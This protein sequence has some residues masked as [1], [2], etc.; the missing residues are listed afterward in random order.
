M[1]RRLYR[2]LFWSVERKG[3]K[4]SKNGISEKNFFSEWT[5][6]FVSYSKT[7]KFDVFIKIRE[8]KGTFPL[9]RPFPYFYKT[10]ENWRLLTRRTRKS[11]KNLDSPYLWKL[12]DFGSNK[13]KVPLS[14]HILERGHEN[15]ERPFFTIRLYKAVFRNR[16][17]PG[18]L[19]A[20]ILWKGVDRKS[21]VLKFTDFKFSE[22]K[23]FNFFIQKKWKCWWTE[24]HSCAEF[25]FAPPH[26]PF[27]QSRECARKMRTTRENV[28]HGKGSFFQRI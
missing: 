24:F 28:S 6:V 8:K 11:S 15:I 17:T 2:A 22:F 26:T 9:L 19:A 7:L 23:N 12:P 3:M 1:A 27:P 18:N 14:S 20:K 5:Y 4:N 10:E 16:L 13:G 25:K 21:D